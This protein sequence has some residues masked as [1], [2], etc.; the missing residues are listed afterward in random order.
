MRISDWS[1]DVCSSDLWA[2][3]R[4]QQVQLEFDREHVAGVIEQAV[5]GVTSCHI[6]DRRD[7]TAMQKAVLLREGSRKWKTQD[8][9]TFADFIEHCPDRGHE[10]LSL[11][12]PSHAVFHLGQAHADLRRYTS[13]D[14]PLGRAS[15]RDRVCQYV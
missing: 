3:G 6:R 14:E 5:G 9:P 13:C 1:S 2:K 12:A 11:E 8:D 7:H 4:R 15:S 10:G